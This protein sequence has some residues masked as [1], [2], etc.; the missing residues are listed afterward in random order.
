VN[1]GHDIV[2]FLA[3][4]DVL[5]LENRML[6]FAL[7]ALSFKIQILD[8]FD[9]LCALLLTDESLVFQLLVVRIDDVKEVQDLINNAEVCFYL[10]KESLGDHVLIFL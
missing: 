10:L 6:K 1:V 8:A 9:D 3:H 7:L 2:A 5:V 4:L